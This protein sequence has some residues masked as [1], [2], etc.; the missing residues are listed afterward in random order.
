MDKA[1][2]GQPQSFD[3]AAAKRAL[4]PTALD[5]HKRQSEVLIVAGSREYLG[6]ALLCARGAFRSGAG[7]V[8]LALPQALAQ[9]AVMALPEA[10]IAP[11]PAEDALGL[12]HLE[13]LLALAASA[14]AAAVGPGLGRHEGT[15]ALVAALWK[16]L[17]IPAV[18][19]AD[20]LFALPL[21]EAAGAARVL[22]P[23]EGELKR[24][25]GPQALNE[26]R[27]AAVLALARAGR[28]VALLKGPATLVALPDGAMTQNSSGNPALATAGSGDVLSGAIAALMAQG[29]AP[30]A[31]AGLA[32][33]AHGLAADAWVR[34]HGPRGLL[35]SELADALPAAFAQ[36][37]L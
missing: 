31:A 33:W 4:P 26:G 13:A 12:E 25:L 7:M 29:A 36:A 37:A 22:T 5:A 3:G 28:C 16:R 8:R 20:A 15:L 24:L 14:H 1:A 30:F 34:T 19:D 35:A 9:S 23:H 17:S 21:A 6:A 32:A 18:F 11:L 10:V 2:A 27:V